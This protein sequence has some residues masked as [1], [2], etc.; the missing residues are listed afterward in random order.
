MKIKTKLII[1]FIPIL[2][3][4]HSCSKRTTT[5]YY[6]FLSEFPHSKMIVP[7][8]SIEPLKSWNDSYRM[9]GWAKNPKH[10]KD[11]ILIP[12]SRKR[13]VLVFGSL[14]KKEKKINFMVKS[15][16]YTKAKKQPFLNVLINGHMVSHLPFPPQKFKKISV[17]AKTKH[18][19]IGENFLEF[20]LCPPDYDIDGKFWLALK[21]IRIE[22][23]SPS[24]KKYPQTQF[25]PCRIITHKSLFQKQHAIEQMLNTTLDYYLK[26]P[27]HSKIFFSASLKMPYKKSLSGEK[28][29]IYLET[30]SAESHILFDEN[31]TKENIKKKTPFDVDL[32]AYCGQIAKI[33][34]IFLKDSQDRNFSPR[35]LLWEPRIEI[36]ETKKKIEETASEKPHFQKP[37]NILIYLV[38]CLRPDHLPFFNYKKNIAPFM[39]EFAK[40]SIIFKNAY[41]QGSWTRLSVGALFTGFYPFIHK[42]TTLKSG[43]GSEFVTM[44]EILQQAGY[45]TNGI[46]SNAGIKEYFNFNQ[47]FD[48][49][50]YHSNLNGGLSYKLNEYAFSQLEKKKTPFFLYIHTMDPHRPYKIK[51]EFCFDIPEKSSHP[52]RLITVNKGNKKKYTVDLK[53]VLAQYDASIRQ[54]DKSFGDLMNKLKKLDLYD[55]TMII[56]MSDHGE[57]FYEHEGFAHGQTLYQEVIHHLLVIKLPNQVM[58]GKIVSENVQEIDI[59]PTILDLIGEPQPVYSLG[60][61][62][63]NLLLTS[64]GYETPFHDEIFV[65]TGTTLQLNAIIHGH[66]KLIHDG[67]KWTDNLKEYELYNFKEDPLEKFNLF[68]RN[69]IASEY[70]KIRLKRWA[71]SQGELSKLGK[72]GLSKALT[73]KDIEELKAL[74]YIH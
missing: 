61:S 14:N 34:F 49:F 52:D 60:K 15:F 70:L 72:E 18:L 26:I 24:F 66:W 68:S 73:E 35:L 7:V 11:A 21:N 3:F 12:T 25:K 46:S 2:L 59:L 44:A 53:H 65:E 37:I 57:E 63:K 41:A 6:D 45:H 54:N 16:L 17:Q 29:V 22:E 38:D 51:K 8:K 40:D 5:Y 4:F 19:F 64:T 58:A 55:N 74:G 28:L 67:N 50:K 48:Y 71:E 1:I 69:P 9:L 56:L 20:Q 27:K 33:S 13:A 10:E 42:A 39:D 62:L 30:A 23:S 36:D 47:G 43:L 31:F 32:S